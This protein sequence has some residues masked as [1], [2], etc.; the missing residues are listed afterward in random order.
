[1]VDALSSHWDWL[2]CPSIAQQS[3][4]QKTCALSSAGCQVVRNVI[5][6]Q[7]SLHPP[8]SGQSKV[9]ISNFHNCKEVFHVGL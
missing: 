2:S 5:P 7:L 4:L 6:R 9:Y 1:M 8:H 3:H